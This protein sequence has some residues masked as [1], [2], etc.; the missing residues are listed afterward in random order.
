MLVYSICLEGSVINKFLFVIVKV[1][2]FVYYFLFKE[3]LNRV[4]DDLLNGA[5]LF[6]LLFNVLS[7]VR[8]QL[9]ASPEDYTPPSVTHKTV[10]H[11]KAICHW[12]LMETEV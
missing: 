12:V 4:Q 6:C 9:N 10:S 5:I 2:E 1:L 7:W 3:E 8:L 11:G